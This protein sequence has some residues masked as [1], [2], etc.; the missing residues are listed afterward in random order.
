MSGDCDQ[1]RSSL[2]ARV[3]GRA[4][5]PHAVGSRPDAQTATKRPDEPRGPNGGARCSAFPSIQ[6]KLA[7]RGNRRT[8]VTQQ[9]C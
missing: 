2:A 5:D 8:D 6:S 7:P 4:N 3:S 9:E 1:S